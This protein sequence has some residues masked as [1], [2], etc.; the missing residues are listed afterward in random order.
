MTVY[1]VTSGQTS[2][3][4]LTNGDYEYVSSGGTASATIIE[5][6]GFAIISSGGK[7]SV[8][9]IDSGGT[10][11]VSSGG[12]A[13]STTVG[14]GGFEVISYGGVASGTTIDSGSFEVISGGGSAFAAQVQAGGMQ[15]I[16]FNG[17]ASGTTVQSG[18]AELIGF[19][20]SASKTTV[21]SG[22]VAIVSGGGTAFGTVLHS[23]A[24]LIVLPSAIVSSGTSSAGSIVVSTGAVVL[25]ANHVT[26]VAAATTGSVLGGVGME[27]VLPGGVA[28][29][30]IV[31][32]GGRQIILSSGVSSDTA[33]G[34][35]GYEIISKG[36]V[37]SDAAA[38]PGG[39][40][41]ISFGGMASN[42]TV[43][44][45]GYA[46]VSNGGSVT[47]V[48]LS[49]GTVVVEN[50][51][52]LQGGFSFAA[53]NGLLVISGTTMPTA[54]LS[55]FG[56]NE[57][58]DLA[59]IMSSAGVSA[60]FVSSSSVLDVTSGGT[61]YQLALDPAHNYTGDTFAVSSA[62]G[63]IN[64]SIACFLSG[65]RI[66]TSR[67][68]VAVEC[69]V[70]G[71]MVRNRAG[72][73]LPVKW[74]GHRRI[75]CHR[76]ARPWDVW[77]V[78]VRPGAFGEGR[79]LADLWLSPDHGV[80][81]DGVLI[82]IRYLANG[83]TVAQEPRKSVTYWHVELDRHDVIL[84]EGLP[85]E[86]YL[87][88]GNRGTFANGGTLVHL[89]PDFPLRVWA[90]AAC[91]P[92]VRGGAELEAARSLL[93]ER[94]G[95]LGH[96]TTRNPGL[97][98]IAAGQELRPEI[99]GGRVN[100]FRVPRAARG[101]RLASRSVVPAQVRA[102]S[103]DHRR[104]GVAVSAVTGDGAMIRLADPRLGSGWHDIERAGDDVAWR[105]TDGNAAIALSGGH[106]LD[107][108]VAIIERYWVDD[109]PPDAHAVATLAQ[110]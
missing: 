5:A 12:S 8:T 17:G 83:R 3:L 28:A 56:F 14:S 45:G 100:R 68:N 76:H 59:S 94:A 52:V 96:A 103:T 75:D 69:L 86:S 88:T 47:N 6:G 16:L 64:I 26:S 92:L 21:S 19:G 49:G 25:S 43:E 32:S 9:T 60:T 98:L 67:G 22:G 15:S 106:V 13:Y 108:E 40:E 79:P 57:T 66:L 93:L 23:G 71:D 37:A 82:P 46:V 27:L 97:R 41:V 95:L 4:T 81:V 62:G 24:T 54:T 36:G 85:C 20:G 78:R 33:I 104:L 30:T 109:D 70:V 11:I 65:S 105:W 99:V 29:D 102:A 1:D 55:G 101:L 84:A 80:F 77:P 39:Y 58:V 91:A 34:S 7:A 44:P 90:L 10:E 110:V 63:G 38:G 107:I 72:E 2:A 31:E 61:T 73:R 18:G 35:G 51:G 48:T 89:H 42:T 50:G 53:P 74:I 87:D